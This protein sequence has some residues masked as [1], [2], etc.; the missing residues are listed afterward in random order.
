M[1]ITES[2]IEASGQQLL[3]ELRSLARRAERRLRFQ[4]YLSCLIVFA[5]VCVGLLTIDCIFQREEVGLR[6]L[7]WFV[8]LV[9]T[10]YAANRWLRPLQRLKVRP[11]DIAQ[12]VE[13]QQPSWSG[14]ITTALQLAEI[15]REDKRFGSQAFRDAALA[16]W[17]ALPTKPHWEAI[18]SNQ[19]LHKLLGV[20]LSLIGTV[21]LL[22][23][24]W[25]DIG[26]H[27]LQRLFIPW[28]NERWPRADQLELANLPT[29]V[30]YDSVVQLEV[31][32]RRP[33]LP[34]DVTIEIRFP[35]R[36]EASVISI[37][38]QRVADLAVA[39]LPPILQEIQVRAV[40]GDDRQMPWQSIR[41]VEVPG[42]KQYKFKIQPPY[43]IRQSASALQRLATSS[44]DRD[45][46]YEIMGQ[47]I[48]ILAGSFV[49]F[50]G[51]LA[52]PIRNISMQPLMTSSIDN[53]AAT[54]APQQNAAN[55]PWRLQ[56]SPDQ[57]S[58]NSM[59]LAET[60]DISAGKISADIPPGFTL[61]HQSLAWAVRME[62]LEQVLLESP[63]HWKVEAIPDN[64]PEVVLESPQ[65]KSLTV[66]A[67][68]FL[69]AVCRDDWG[70]RSIV[71]K[72]T[73]GSASEMEYDLPITVTP[74]D[75]QEQKITLEWDF[76]AQ[77]ASEGVQLKPQEQLSIH[78]E[79]TDLCG[80][81]S[82]S[83][84]E[85]LVLES[86]PRQ[87]ER[88]ASRQS[89]LSAQLAELETAQES[90]QDLTRRTVQSW[91]NHAPSQQH[92][93][94]IQGVNQLQQMI[95]QQL[96]DSPG[97]LHSEI[98]RLLQM[99]A[100]NQLQDSQLA[101]QLEKMQEQVGEIG[102]TSAT[103]AWKLSGSL[104]TEL[105]KAADLTDK[106]QL[107][108]LANQIERQQAQTLSGLRELNN[109]L[110]DS[111]SINQLRERLLEIAQR[112][113]RLAVDTNQLN[114]D[115]LTKIPVDYAE[116]L[117][118]ASTIQ[119]ELMTIM[120]RWLSNVLQIRDMA[121]SDT[122]QP[123][124]H[125]LNEA[126]R[127]L[128]DA[129]VVGLMRSSSIQLKNEKLG[130]A[131]QAH[132]E[133]LQVIQE[134]LSRFADGAVSELLDSIASQEQRMQILSNQARQLAQQQMQVA[135]SLS[136]AQASLSAQALADDQAK[137]AQATANLDEQISDEQ[138]GETL[139]QA[140]ELQQQAAEAV[141][142]QSMAQA[143]EF[144]EQAAK[145]LEE[146]ARRLAQKAQ[147]ANQ[148]VM[149]QQMF[150]L[151]SAI[152]KVVLEQQALMPSY[153]RLAQL[154][155]S[156]EL[157]AELAVQSRTL[158]QQQ[159]AV[160]DTLRKLLSTS[161][162]LKVFHWVLQ[163]AESD[164]TRAVAATERNRFKPTAIDAA[165]AGLH[166]LKLAG[167]SLSGSPSNADK[168]LPEMDNRDNQQIN[169]QQSNNG[170]SMPPLAS[171][172]LIRS[173][174]LELKEQTSLLEDDANR[175]SRSLEL[176]RQ[177]QELGELLE[178][179]VVEAQ[180]QQEQGP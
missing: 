15:G 104:L 155:Q 37:P 113:E 39:S 128:V 50:E 175:S 2:Q 46:I 178:Q 76:A 134:A 112:Q 98:D 171:L 109:Q 132:K 34:E 4:A 27:A 9:A 83:N 41:V 54:I 86:K 124:V 119:G 105:S 120:E 33:P 89:S 137:L 157:A 97:S 165:K 117:I 166:K 49:R 96:I 159:T 141:A 115:S 79:A 110:A 133:I 111:D 11:L 121:P 40:G 61:I 68:L 81:K 92:L 150:E 3:G 131:I 38:T 158:V 135:K 122:F 167:E 57:V 149:L 7:S 20:L 177:Q 23:A 179:L 65:L 151:A 51:E 108:L 82:K 55:F 169:N 118:H 142:K 71:A 162:Q 91:Q 32:D 94:A 58:V 8:L 53:S 126:A 12:W 35:E 106:S 16:Q 154:Q 44:V 116:R 125:Q 130:P 148:Q 95:R 62:T 45:G 138:I 52:L 18:V 173:L 93:D 136:G 67:P 87:L 47:R 144:A 139:R 29:A 73:I 180:S 140:Q 56:L 103:Q 123:L 72:L 161:E 129:Q 156:S 90:A 143:S 17:Q 168:D 36:A 153:Q 30:G 102:N 100:E 145:K 74:L 28:S 63:Q 1:S 174:Q 10:V 88:I 22:V 31:R 43:Y 26:M 5:T 66:G 42:W 78:I 80:N 24:V 176:I 172:K 14:Q 64:A 146:V 25:P 59:M 77:L 60:T 170:M 127:V 19:S 160:R 75:T 21:F 152:E 101:R 48:R 114:I 164:L 85:R 13:S 147:Q 6:W 69:R 99:L 84:I 107:L 70:L 163:Q